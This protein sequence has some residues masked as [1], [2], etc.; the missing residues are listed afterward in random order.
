MTTT[1]KIRYGPNANDFYQFNFYLVQVFTQK[2]TQDS[3]PFNYPNTTYTAAEAFT[4]A[5]PM[6][7]IT[8]EFPVRTQPDDVTN[9]TAPDPP[10]SSPANVITDV[11][12][13]IR[14]FKDYVKSHDYRTIFFLTDTFWLKGHPNQEVVLNEVSFVSLAEKKE[15]DCTLSFLTA[16]NVIRDWE[17]P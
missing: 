12:D 8:I 11:D 13:Q 10:F 15:A 9:G 7:E 1:L 6:L 4:W 17:G 14:F 16:K 5:G 2:L 3:V